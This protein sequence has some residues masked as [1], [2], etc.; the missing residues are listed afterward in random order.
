MSFNCDKI[1]YPKLAVH[2][3]LNKFK[4]L[5]KDNA[6]F[7]EELTLLYNFIDEYGPNDNHHGVTHALWVTYNCMKLLKIALEKYPTSLN[8][9]FLN[10]KARLLQASSMLHNVLDYKYRE[11]MSQEEISKIKLQIKNCLRNLNYTES[12]I[13]IIEDVINNISFKKVSTEKE[14]IFNEPSINIKKIIHQWV[15][16]SDMIEAIGIN[17]TIRYWRCIDDFSSTIY[18]N[19]ILKRDEDYLDEVIKYYDDKL[20]HIYPKYIKIDFI[21]ELVK[22][23]HD[24]LLT[25]YRTYHSGKEGK[26][27][28]IKQLKIRMLSELYLPSMENMLDKN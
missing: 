26:E 14:L 20:L 12:E 13:D 18:K 28:C 5:Y 4:I 10:N 27:T 15:S 11:R 7:K 1:N 17:G 6:L 21:K 24:E 2:R 25:F 19:K 22:P 9:V 3:I 8:Y 16:I 23:L